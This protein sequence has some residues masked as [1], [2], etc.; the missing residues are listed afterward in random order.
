MD[1]EHI[2]GAAEKAKGAVKE[3]AGKMAGDEKLRA[4]GQLDKAK[5]AAH[6]AAGDMKEEAAHHGSKSPHEAAH[7]GPKSTHE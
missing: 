7:H 2:K 6:K 4:E 1:R 3:T 5:G